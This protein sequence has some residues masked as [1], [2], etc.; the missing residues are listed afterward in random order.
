MKVFKNL[1]ALYYLYLG[2]LLGLNYDTNK[3]VG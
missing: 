3:Y 2:L 1:T